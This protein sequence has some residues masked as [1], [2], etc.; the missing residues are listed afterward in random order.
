[1]RPTSVLAFAPA[2]PRDLPAIGVSPFPM[3]IQFPFSRYATFLRCIGIFELGECPRV[4]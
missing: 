2:N 1:M 4:G 3:P